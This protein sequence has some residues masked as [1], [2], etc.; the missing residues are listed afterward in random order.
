MYKTSRSYAE[1]EDDNDALNCFREKF[2]HPLDKNGKPLIYF[3]GNSLGLQPKSTPGKLEK[4]LKIWKERGVQGQ[5][6]RWIK[7]HEKLAL[8]SANIVG[9]K[10]SEVVV[11]NALTINIHLLLVSFYRPTKERY[12]VVIEKGAFPSD[13]YA[14]DSQLHFH[15]LNKQDALIEIQPQEGREIIQ[16]E[17]ILNIIKKNNSEIAMIYLGGIN[18]LTG[19]LFD[20]E[21]ITAM[22]KKYGIVVGFNLAHCAGN[23][24]LFLH[25]WGVDFAAWCTYKYLCAGPGSPSGVFIHENH[26]NWTGPRFTGWWGHN[27]ESRFRMPSKFDPILSAEGWQISNAPILGMAPLISSLKLY[28]SAT[29]QKIRA[30]GIKLTGYLEFLIK[31]HIKGVLIITPKKRGS[32]ISLKIE[33]GE[34]VFQKITDSGLVC[35][36]REP[37]VIRITPHPLFN[38][39]LDVFRAVNILKDILK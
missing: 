27:K 35:D 38:S 34:K 30:K 15:G 37:N 16:E 2:Y 21:S 13:Q 28:E 23:V 25:K 39:Y 31:K 20:M 5:E 3:C 29:M 14:I 8:P 6:N 12:K 32:Q 10:S 22:A 33:N 24:E 11:M 1:R 17:D 7:Y 26:H 9:A 19:Q 36:Y 18:Y 4:E